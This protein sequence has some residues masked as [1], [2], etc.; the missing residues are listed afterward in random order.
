MAWILGDGGMGV[1]LWHGSKVTVEREC[2]YGM[3]VR[4]RRNGNVMAWRLVD[5]G[6]GVLLWHGS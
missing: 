4:R 6:M 1:L 5:S 2:C 3:D